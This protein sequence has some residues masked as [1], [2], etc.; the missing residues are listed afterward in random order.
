MMDWYELLMKYMV[1]VM[2]EQGED[3]IQGRDRPLVFN[4]YEWEALV[5][6]SKEVA[7]AGS[8]EIP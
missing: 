7:E 2:E 5:S 6:L 1:H 3:F 8:P 4:E